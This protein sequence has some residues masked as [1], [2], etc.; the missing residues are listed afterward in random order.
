MTTGKTI[1]LNRWTFVDKVMSLLFNM[2][3]RLAVTFLPRGISFNFMAAVTICSHF[4][5]QENKVCHCFHCF[6]IYLSWSANANTWIYLWGQEGAQYDW[7]CF[8]YLT[9]LSVYM[10]AKL[11]QSCLTLATLWTVACQAPLSMEILRARILEWV[12]ILSSQKPLW[13]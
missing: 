4:G 6:P 2:L 1:A 10:C 13:S 5:A 11:L 3:C 9:N 7:L 8:S 12:A